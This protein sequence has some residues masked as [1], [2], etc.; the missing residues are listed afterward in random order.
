MTILNNAFIGV[1]PKIPIWLPISEDDICLLN[2]AVFEL[3]LL[4]TKPDT[5]F[6]VEGEYA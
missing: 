3:A 1:N 2:V 5:K 6:T 4:E